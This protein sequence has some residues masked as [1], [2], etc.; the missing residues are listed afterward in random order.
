MKDDFC[1]KDFRL[2]LHYFLCFSRTSYMNK[3]DVLDKIFQDYINWGKI[4]IFFDRLKIKLTFFF[5]V[6]K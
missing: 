4:Y 1:F 6:A 5:P 3:I 2:S